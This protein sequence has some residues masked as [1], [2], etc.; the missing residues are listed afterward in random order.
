MTAPSIDVHIPSRLAERPQWVLWKFEDRD[1][2]RT[3]VPYQAND[4]KAESD[5]PATWTTLDLALA[6]FTTGQ[7]NGIG[8]VFSKDDPFCGI[9]LDKCRDPQTGEIEAWAQAIVGSIPT[10]SEISPSGTGVHIIAEASLPG[11]RRRRNRVECYQDG[12]FFTFTAMA[13]PNSTIDVEPVQEQ[14]EAFY[15]KH[16]AE[17]ER[18]ARPVMPANVIPLSFG[19]EELLN[20]ARNATNKE[21]FIA[22][23]DN[24]DWSGFDSRSEA[25]AS[26]CIHLAFYWQRDA[27]SM[28][29][30]FRQ[31][32]MMRDKWDAQRGEGKTYGS[33]TI[34]FAIARQQNTY[35]P[36]GFASRN[37]V[38]IGGR[39]SADDV[40]ASEPPVE[41]PVLAL[42]PGLREMAVHG[43]QSKG[44]PPDYYA[45]PLLVATGA[46]MGPGFELAIKPDFIIGSNLY[47]A[48]VGPP[49]SAKSPAMEDAL[50][51][52]EWLQAERYRTYRKAMD[53]HRKA[54]QVYEDAKKGAKP[55][56]PVEP[57]LRSLITN[58]ATVEALIDLLE[59]HNGLL[60]SFD[61]LAGWMGSLNQYRAAGR[62]NDR[63]A[64]LSFWARRFHSK[65]RRSGTQLIERPHLSIIGG[66]QP[67]RLHVLET[68]GDDGLLA[69]F[70]WALPETKASLWSEEVIPSRVVA[71]AK[72]LFSR[73]VEG[74]ESAEPMRVIFS[75]SARKLWIE[76]HDQRASEMDSDG[77]PSRLRGTWAKLPSQAGRIAIILHAAEDGSETLSDATLER[78]LAI[79]DYFAAHAQRVS[80]VLA[81][82][83]ESIH[84]KVLRA[85]KDNGRISKATLSSQVLQRNV[86]ASR[87]DDALSD[88]EFAG[89]ITSEKEA[90]TGGRPAVIW[91]LA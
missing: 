80:R 69:R 87:L 11:P 72:T 46:A 29:R 27:V 42:P 19:D 70:L 15:H 12:R 37:N 45:V 71:N 1:G 73:L 39:I 63:E 85:V 89:L 9:D 74:S 34:A 6:A 36:R 61:E 16:L 38:T 14:V 24:G 3:K 43:S 53:E 52:L 4:S 83:R 25:D 82:Q 33:N 66:I 31:S 81:A 60:L 5:N 65:A 40:L 88:L 41:F 58:D 22:L 78:A 57:V 59:R 68:D 50:G 8:F 10:Y 91:K 62:G 55:N 54:M 76:W 28:D 48:V 67:D 75:A 56:R 20:V 44:C 7:F 30:M 26:L 51:P 64:Y 21:N 77:F 86:S 23:F 13:L 49:G 32:A 90:S 17:P 35:Q 47:G 79:I 84:L 2:N 18:P